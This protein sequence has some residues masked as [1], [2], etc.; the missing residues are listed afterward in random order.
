MALNMTKQVS[1]NLETG[2][3]KIVNISSRLPTV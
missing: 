3:V 1:L 2:W